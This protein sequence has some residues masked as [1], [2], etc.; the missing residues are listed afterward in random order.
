VGRV[1]LTVLSDA[2]AESFFWGEARVLVSAGIY[3]CSRASVAR[4]AAELQAVS[5][6][7]NRYITGEIVGRK[8]FEGC[9]VVGPCDMAGGPDYLH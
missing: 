3:S 7:I 9:G 1:L 5:V 6:Y 2:T 8:P 4:V